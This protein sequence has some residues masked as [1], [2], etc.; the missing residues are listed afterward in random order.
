MIMGP[1]LGTSGRLTSAYKRTCLH[2]PGTRVL[3]RAGEREALKANLTRSHKEPREACTLYDVAPRNHIESGAESM[4][5]T[6]RA[7]HGCRAHLRYSMR[8]AC[9]APRG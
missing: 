2:I 8:R 9:C 6:A 5:A 7:W 1:S 3:P 4:D